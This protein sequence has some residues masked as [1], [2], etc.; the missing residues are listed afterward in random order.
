MKDLGS[1]KSDSRVLKWD[2]WRKLKG[3]K[4]SQ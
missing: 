4:I 1:I 3:I 2:L